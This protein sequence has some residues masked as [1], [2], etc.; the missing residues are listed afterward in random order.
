[1]NDTN[2]PLSKKLVVGM[3]ENKKN[4]CAYTGPHDILVA[5]FEQSAMTPCW[6]N[7]FVIVCVSLIVRHLD[8]VHRGVLSLNLLGHYFDLTCLI[9]KNTVLLMPSCSF[10]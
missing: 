8:W 2:I 1:M 4:I 9:F 3:K 5:L 6:S 7:V 10:W